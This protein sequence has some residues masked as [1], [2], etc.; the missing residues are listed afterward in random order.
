MATIDQFKAALIGGGARPNQFRVT[1]GFPANAIQTATGIAGAVIGGAVGQ[2]IGQIGAAVGNITGT[3]AGNVLQFLCKAASIPDSSVGQ[4]PVS[5]RGRQLKLAG[6]RIFSPWSIQIVNDTNF[7]LRNAFEQWMDL[8]NSHKT[9]IS[10][11][12][13]GYFQDWKVEQL[14]RNDG[15][16]ATYHLRG[17][18]P[19]Q[20]SDIQ[21]SFDAQDQIEEFNVTLEYQYWEHEGITS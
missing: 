12:N 1:G 18:W 2:A 20:V 7:A 3:N 14:D 4:I 9:N 6:D 21:L 8:I 19:I 10:P 11:S 15:I 17:C 5:Y 16:L 13:I